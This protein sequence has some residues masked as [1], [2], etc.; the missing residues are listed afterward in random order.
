MAAKL[1]LHFRL[2]CGKIHEA[3]G[4]EAETISA[5]VNAGASGITSLE[6]FRAGWAVRLAAYIRELRKMGVPIR[7][8]REPHDGGN[9]GRYILENHVEI[10]WRSDE[11]EAA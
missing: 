2:P 4:R 1:K 7:T 8:T 6:T 3:V 5:L 10:T 9:H 11:M